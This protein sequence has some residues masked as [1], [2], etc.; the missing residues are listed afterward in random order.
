MNAMKKVIALLARG[1]R[2]YFSRLFKPLSEEEE[3]DRN[4]LQ[5]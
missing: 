5:P 4:E 2:W 3:R 1:A